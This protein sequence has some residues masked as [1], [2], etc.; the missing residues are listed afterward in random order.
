MRPAQIEMVLRAAGLACLADTER[1][2][3][4]SG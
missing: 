1:L 2:E 4:E 3:R